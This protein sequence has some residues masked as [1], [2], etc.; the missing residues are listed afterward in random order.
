M[1]NKETHENIEALNKKDVQLK[2]SENIQKKF[3]RDTQINSLNEK[4]N[5]ENN[6]SYD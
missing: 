6:F 5:F 1:E 3:T 4:I 2:I